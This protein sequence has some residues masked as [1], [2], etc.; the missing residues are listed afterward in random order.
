MKVLTKTAI[1]ETRVA[2]L[3]STKTQINKPYNNKGILLA[4][5]FI[6]VAAVEKHHELKTQN[7]PKDKR[8]Q[9]SINK[10]LAS[11]FL[12]INIRLSKFW[13]ILVEVTCRREERGNCDKRVP[14]LLKTKLE[15][16]V[17]H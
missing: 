2:T 15:Y 3:S 12:A 16:G 6:S 11:A 9:F 5:V 14:L 1:D 4:D 7:Q 13:P 17:V 10:F 8:L